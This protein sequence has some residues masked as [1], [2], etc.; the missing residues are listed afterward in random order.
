MKLLLSAFALRSAAAFGVTSKQGFSS[1]ALRA[2]PVPLANGSMS[3]DRVC[4]EIRCKYEGDKATSK[5]LEEI[6]KVVAEYLPAIKAVS[7]DMKVNRMV[8]GGCLD[9]KLQMTVGLDAFGPWDGEG[10]PPEAEILA[11][12]KEIKGVS[13]VETQTLTNMEI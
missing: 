10:F 3:F 8:C 13:Q 6:G 1:T 2:E 4:R 7:P 9:F 5:S 12:L 11:K